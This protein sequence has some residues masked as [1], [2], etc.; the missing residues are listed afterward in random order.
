MSS[1]GAAGPVRVSSPGAAGPARSTLGAAG[2]AHVST[3][4]K[5][6]GILRVGTDCS[7]WEAILLALRSMGVPFQNQFSSDVDPGVREVLRHNYGDKFV[8]YEDATDRNIKNM[9]KVDLYHAGFP[10]QPFSLAGLGR[11]VED[12]RGTVIFHLL[13]YVKV[14]RP[15]LVVFENVRGLVTKHAEVVN[16]IKAELRKYEYTVDHK[17]LNA[18]DFGVPHNRERVFIV[19][20]LSRACTKVPWPKRL[21]P[22]PLAKI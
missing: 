15:T 20:I 17:V 19:G 3:T 8:L 4:T 22:V 2:A 7:G 21:D 5:Q 12:P 9:P 6:A 13:K 11:G 18:K 10:C 16:Y 1:A 14:H